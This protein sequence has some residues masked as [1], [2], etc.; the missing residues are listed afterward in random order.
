M[1]TYVYH[2]DRDEQGIRMAAALQEFLGVNLGVSE[3][4]E[5]TTTRPVVAS[6]LEG[7]FG[8]V[9]EL[10][11]DDSLA[12]IADR[13][14]DAM[15]AAEEARQFDG[16]GNP[17][18]TIEETQADLDLMRKCPECELMF[19]PD[20]DKQIYCSK[21]CANRVYGRNY[22]SKKKAGGNG[23]GNGHAPIVEQTVGMAVADSPQ[24]QAV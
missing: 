7:L 18:P 5:L 9:P 20:R 24:E 14:L 3:C 4:L 12:E 8:V 11:Y 19:V 10:R 21:R 15:M 17:L 13:K 23:N 6:V 22:Q 2:I 16:F 1:T